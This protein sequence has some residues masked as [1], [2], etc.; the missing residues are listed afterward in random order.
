MAYDTEWSADL[1]DVNTNV[2]LRKHMERRLRGMRAHRQGYDSAWL[3][4]SRFTQATTSPKLRA[5]SAGGVTVDSPAANYNVGMK[6]NTSLLDSRAVGASEVLG[7]G[8]YSGLSAPSRPWFKLTLKDA[9]LRSTSGVKLWL[10]EVERRIYEL[11]NGTNFYTASKSGYRELGQFGV[12]AGIMERH[13]RVGMVCHPLEVGEYWFAQGDDGTVDTLYRRTDLTVLQH[14]QKFLRGRRPNDA[15]P[16][17]IVEAYDQGNYDQMFCV[18][19]GI[20]PNDTYNPELMGPRAKPWRS[21]YWSPFCEE[22]EK[23]YEQKAMLSVEGF[24]SKPFWSPRWETTGS[25][26]PYSRTSPGFNGLADVRQLQL[27]VLRKQQ[28]ID[29]TVKPA[30]GGPA[31]LNNVHAALQPGRIT[32]MA[33]MD[34]SSFFPIWEI[35]P[36]AIREIA[37]DKNETAEAVDRA[38]YANLF[39]AITNMQGIQPRNIE[40]IAKRNEEQLTQLGPVVERVNQ[41][42]LEVAIDRAFEILMSAGALDDIPMPEE[43]QGQRIEVEFVSVLASAQRLIGLGGIER[44]FGFANSVAGTF[45]EALDNLDVDITGIAAKIMRGKDAVAEVR[46]Q[47]QQA[48][49]QAAQAEQMAQMAPAAKAGAEAAQILFD[50]P[51]IGSTSLAQRLLG[52]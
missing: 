17:K 2:G 49:A 24:N 38:F 13:W 4:I 43:L 20:E 31:T 28:A 46:S 7:N 45:P 34:K 23:G 41:E 29:Y 3:E 6:V 48:Q 42:K 8:M 47:R 9:A 50:A 44:T 32:A 10:D 22:A 12:D 26:D 39:M 16:R 5:Y 36:Q 18:Y 11:L 27:Q 52:A 1:G 51:G 15:L 14:Y 40:E 25:G 35:V 30:L 33:Q 19:H 21:A 37:A